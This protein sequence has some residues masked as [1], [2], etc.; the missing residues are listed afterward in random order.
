MEC[1]I[2]LPDHFKFTTHCLSQAV[3]GQERVLNHASQIMLNVRL[4]HEHMYVASQHCFTFLK[5]GLLPTISF[6][7]EE[8]I[9]EYMNSV[10]TFQSECTEELSRIVEWAACSL[11]NL[12]Y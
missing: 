9:I 5:N 12:F 10:V 4:S 11:F 2:S 7:Q 6:L 3:C 8:F 1:G